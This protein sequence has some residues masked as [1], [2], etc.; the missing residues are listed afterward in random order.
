MVLAIEVHKKLDQI[1][2]ATINR[3]V[4]FVVKELVCSSNILKY[5]KEV[6]SF[7]MFVNNITCIGQKAKDSQNLLTRCLLSS[8]NF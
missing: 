5:R 7:I 8:G 4:S 1:G 3:G 2:F 6:G